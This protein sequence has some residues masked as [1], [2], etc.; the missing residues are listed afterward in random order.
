VADGVCVVLELQRDAHEAALSHSKGRGTLS[1]P[2]GVTVLEYSAL[3]LQISAR[4][5]NILR[6]FTVLLSSSRQRPGYFLSLGC[7]RLILRPALCDLLS[8]DFTLCSL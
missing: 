7:G 5:P 6:D 3:R 1:Q 4:T 8:Y 2:N